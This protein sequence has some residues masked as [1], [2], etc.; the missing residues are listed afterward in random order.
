MNDKKTIERLFTGAAFTFFF[1]ITCYKLTHASLWFDETIE[2]WYSKIMFGPLPFDGENTAGTTN[3]YQRIITTYQPPLYNFIMFFW[4]KIHSSEWWF[5]FFGVVMGFLANLAIFKTLKKYASIYAAILSVFFS[6]CVYYLYFYWQEC[7]EYC[8][9]LCSLSWTFYF[10]MNVIHDAN[11]KN[12]IIFTISAII[13]VY[14]QYG[15]AFPVLSFLLV[16]YIYIIIKKKHLLTITISYLIAFITTVIPLISL[17]LLK[18]LSFQNGGE[19]HSSQMAFIRNNIFLDIYQSFI[20]VVRWCFF[21]NFGLRVTKLFVLVVLVSAVATCILSKKPYI[22]ALLTVNILTWFT[23]Y[24]AVKTGLYAYGLFG[25]RYNLFFIPTWIISFF[26]FGA[27]LL[28]IIPA[29]QSDIRPLLNGVI[30]CIVFCFMYTNW[31]LGIKNNWPKEDIR[32][33][34]NV[35]LKEEAQYS[36]T[37]VYYAADSGFMYYL[38]NCDLYNPEIEDNINY[39]SW[40]RYGTIEDYTEYVCSIY[41]DEWPN[42]VYLV[43]SHIVDDFSSVTSVFYENGYSCEELFN[44]YNAYVYR[45]TYK[46]QP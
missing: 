36:N 31:D 25:N 8:L 16:T 30:I 24:C 20:T 41:G 18:Q 35:W 34:F 14:S 10:F 37:I 15:A 26:L 9:M 11:K 3:M 42:E 19:I 1:M 13:P 4:L 5:R 38:K 21:E 27:E 43:G 17:F 6:S 33:A 12:I 22:K 32:G 28:Q 39:M 29:K 46:G 23:Y 40:N 45:M 44:S 7:A 2:Y